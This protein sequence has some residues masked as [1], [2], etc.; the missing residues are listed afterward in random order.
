V[1]AFYFIDKEHRVVMSSGSGVLTRGDMIGHQNRLL[2]DPDFDPSFSQ[3]MDFTN[4]TQV[5][6]GPEDIL[7]LAERN[8]FSRNSH[9]A[10]LAGND[11]VYGLSRMFEM[12]REAKGETGVRVFRNRDEAL[13]WAL[14]KE[15]AP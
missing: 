9:R 2:K 6:V 8:V 11:L 13:A 5:D 4:V 15:E 14:G 7:Y 3:I 1:P 10:I 12:I